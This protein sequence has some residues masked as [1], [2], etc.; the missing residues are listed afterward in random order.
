MG[1]A[2]DVLVVGAGSAG[3]VVAARLSEDSSVEV[4][5]C[6]AG[7]DFSG[8]G[9]PAPLLD[10][11]RGPTIDERTDWGL[12]GRSGPDGRVLNLPRGRVAGGCST[13]NATFALRGHPADYDAWDAAGT[14]GWSFDDLLPSFVR[15][16]HDLDFGSAPY[17]GDSGPIPIRRYIGRDESPLAAAAAAALEAAGLPPV[18]DQNAPGAVGV[19]KAPVNAIDGRRVNT[20]L[21][22]LDPARYRPNLTI[23]GG[24]QVQRVVVRAGVAVGVELVNGVFVEAGEVVVCTGAYHSPALLIRSGIGAADELRALGIDVVADVPGVG[25]NLHDHPALSID[26]PYTEPLAGEPVFQLFGTAH[27]STADPRRD[28]PD[29]QLLVGGPYDGDGGRGICFIAA[30]VL[31]PRSRGSVRVTSLDPSAAP[32]IDLGYFTDESDLHR[33]IEGLAIAEEA[34]SQPAMLPVTGGGRLSPGYDNAAELRRHVVAN[35]WT[36]HHPVGTCAMGRNPSAGAVVDADGR[37]HGVERL[38]VVDA[39]ILP[40]IPSANTNV[41]TIAAAEHVIARWRVV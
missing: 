35:A 19:G 27:S 8:D 28:P 31:K 5:L 18:S 41:P 39:S 17:H 7:P 22:Y 30:A 16:E 15:L 14:A 3:C 9:F 13:V 25:R 4:L 26:L 6:E 37:V 10:G 36:Y 21:A 40:E 1:A 23:L 29:L 38:S 2:P 34:V 11:T 12:T 20:G 33:L 32:D 24:T